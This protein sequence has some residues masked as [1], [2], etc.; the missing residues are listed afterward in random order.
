M[1]EMLG[2]FM[3]M[4]SVYADLAIDFL[5]DSPATEPLIYWN[6][7]H[8]KIPSVVDKTHFTI[9]LG[10]YYITSSVINLKSS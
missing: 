7:K 2:R 1:K 9:V 5:H 6:W 8:H 3:G 4:A 10:S